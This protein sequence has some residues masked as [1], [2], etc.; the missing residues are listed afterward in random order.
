MITG[1]I[2]TRW[3]IDDELKKL[4][5]LTEKLERGALIRHSEIETCTGFTKGVAPWA[6]LIDKWKKRVFRDRK[7]TIISKSSVGYRLCTGDEQG[8]TAVRGRASARRKL[9]KAAAA[10]G[11]L[12]DSVLTE[13]GRKF[14]DSFVS[15]IEDVR[16]L[17]RDRQADRPSLLPMPEALPRL[18]IQ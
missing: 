9:A 11:A 10:I 5:E 12:D 2:S 7:I 14:R 18:T 1:K 8:G 6:K 17:M 13:E 16:V 3:L 15:E 4:I